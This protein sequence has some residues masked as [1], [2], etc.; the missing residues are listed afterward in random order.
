MCVCDNV[1]VLCVQL[2]KCVLRDLLEE[3]E[4]QK[5]LLQ[6]HLN[7]TDTSPNLIIIILNL[8]TLVL[9][10]SLLFYC[11]YKYTMEM[12]NKPDTNKCKKL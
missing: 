1:C 7:G 6:V 3:K 2:L 10:R 12:R 4:V 5:N 11:H 8:R 9:R